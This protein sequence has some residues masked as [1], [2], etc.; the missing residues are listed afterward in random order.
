MERTPLRAPKRPAAA[1]APVVATRERILRAASRLM[2]QQGYDGTGIKQ[3]SQEADATLG[4]VY[5]FFPGGKQQLAIGVIRRG[6]QEFI[7]EL[8]TVFAAEEDPARGLVV[9]TRILAEGLRASDWLDGCPVTTTA[10]GTYGRFPELQAAAAEA[11]A[12]WRALVHDKLCATGFAE[13]DARALAH[14]VISTVQGAELT[15]QVS[16]ADDPLNAA[17]AHLARL[18]ASYR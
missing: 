6:S 5:H 18:I 8:S 4:S 7:D 11:F 10:L 2:Q 15:A 1:A 16:R 14:T 13:D 9:F 12:R 17:G 3:I